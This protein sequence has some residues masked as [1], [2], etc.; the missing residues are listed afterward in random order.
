MQATLGSRNTEKE[1]P[2]LVNTRFGVE[3]RT[4]DTR[5][6]VVSTPVVRP[7]RTFLCWS[8]AE[9]WRMRALS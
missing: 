5:T 1:P 6:R 9:A 4:A 7:L 3:E 2:T 8:N